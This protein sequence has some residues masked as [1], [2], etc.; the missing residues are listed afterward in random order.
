MISEHAVYSWLIL[1]LNER[2][3]MKIKKNMKN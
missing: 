1:G 3:S 2:N